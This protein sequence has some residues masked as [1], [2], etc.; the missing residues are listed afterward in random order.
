MNRFAALTL[1]V[2]LVGFVGVVPAAGHPGNA[3]QG[4][5]ETTAQADSCERDEYEPPE[6]DR[7]W[8]VAFIDP[9]QD[10]SLGNWD[11]GRLAPVRLG[12]E[13]SL[14]VSDGESANLTARTVNG[15]Y[16]VVT[17]TLDLGTNGSVRLVE[18]G[19][20]DGAERAAITVSNPGE[21]FSRMLT[22]SV[23]EESTVVSALSGRFVEF[24][25]VQENGTVDVG[26]GT[27]GS[28][29]T[30]GLDARFENVTAAEGW[31][32]H[33]D[34]EAFLNGVAAGKVDP[35]PPPPA[36]EVSPPPENDEADSEPEDTF[37]YDVA[38]SDPATDRTTEGD[39]GHSTVLGFILGLPTIGIGAL[40]FRYAYGFARFGEQLD[41]IGSTTSWD[42]VEPAG[43]NVLLTK[44]SGLLIVG[45]GLYI[46]IFPFL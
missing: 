14:V 19:A 28:E 46:V 20:I 34:G 16:G 3:A 36:D 38:S 18:R 13:C 39:D 24:A 45:F 41:A 12:E 32:L 44:L 23:G 26:L 22:V 4:P 21:S 35:N 33:L 25:V 40:V 7:G 2:A 37:D 6:L 9:I 43:W 15:T 1:L 17:G 11:E 42:E 30:A 29:L 5:A 8:E 27:P 31:R 10:G